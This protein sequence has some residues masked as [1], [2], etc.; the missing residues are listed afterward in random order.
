[1]RRP[2]LFAL[3]A[4]IGAGLLLGPA[5]AQELA[6]YQM[7][8]SLQLVQDRIA[9]GDHAALPMQNRLLEMTDQRLRRA[10][11]DEF[12]DIRNVNA[13]LAFAMSG[14]NPA[15]LEA[16]LATGGASDEARKIGEAVLYYLNGDVARARQAFSHIDTARIDEVLRPSFYLIGATVQG[17]EAP[18][19]ALGQL[20][21]ARL[22]APGTLVEEAALRRSLPLAVAADDAGRFLQASSQYARRFLRSPYAAQFAEDFVDGV[23]QLVSSI[24]HDEIEAIVEWMSRE[25]ARAVYLRLAR[26]AAIEGHGE[27]L[28]FAATRASSIDAD[29]PDLRSE[30]YAN[31]SDVTSQNVSEVM[32]RLEELD[33]DS[34]TRRDRR[35]LH[36]ARAVAAEV[37]APTHGTLP[38]DSDAAAPGN[39]ATAAFVSSARSK[40]DEIDALLERNVR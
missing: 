20:D 4:A 11:R 9:A 13:L 16:A 24:T 35:L 7:V 18:S 5:A 23:V 10:D 32:A 25:Q 30:L 31:I 33:E 22:L 8:R 17:Q 26:L 14:G 6:P 15:T 37:I 19:E 21:R 36:A 12:E 34:L 27:L 2:R 29:E 28:D 39:D 38:G 1:M 3:A 40:L